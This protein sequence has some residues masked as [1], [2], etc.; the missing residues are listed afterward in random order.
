M[1]KISRISS[2]ATASRGTDT[3]RGPKP[4]PL[5]EKLAMWSA[6]G[7]TT[8]GTLEEEIDTTKTGDVVMVIGDFNSKIG[9]DRGGYEDVMGEFGLGERNEKRQRMMEF[10]QGK[11]LCIT[12]NYFYHR[13]QQRYTWRHPDGIQ[14]NCIDYILINKRWKTSVMGTK[15]MRRADFGTSH[16]LLFL[17]IRIK[18]R[19]DRGRNQE[20]VTYNLDKLKNEEVKNCLQSESR[21][22]F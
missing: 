7:M 14:R 4:Q 17:N 20:I 21:R 10:G 6:K 3:P 22:T 5:G 18:F 1:K 8:V 12:N 16:E 9:N 2:M 15:V 19:T 13:E 11:Q